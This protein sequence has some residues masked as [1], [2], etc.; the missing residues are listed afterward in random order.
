M[1]I[2]REECEE[3]LKIPQVAVP[4]DSAAIAQLASTFKLLSEPSRLRVLCALQS[5]PRT[6]S[7]VVT[8]TGIRQANASKQLKRLEQAGLLRRQSRQGYVYYEICNSAI[9]EWCAAIQHQAY[10]C[11]IPV[12]GCSR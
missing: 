8:A 12:M 7:D 9:F 2:P 10:A 3:S 4:M 6:V 5:G 11:P 1:D